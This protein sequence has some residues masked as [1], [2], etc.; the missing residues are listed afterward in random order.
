MP[1]LPSEAAKKAKAAAESGGREPLEPGDY[2][3]RLTS[4]KA[5]TSSNQNPMWVWEFEVLDEPYRGRRLWQNTVLTE[6]AMWK[7]GQ[8]FEAF[9]RDAD[10]D[11]DEIIGERVIATVVQRTITAGARAGQIGNDISDLSPID[12]DSGS[13]EPATAGASAGSDGSS[14]SGGGW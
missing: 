4:V 5:T 1:K 6:K 14:E 12:G 11:T 3:V 13:A 10:T 9:G 8:T 7:V 2:E